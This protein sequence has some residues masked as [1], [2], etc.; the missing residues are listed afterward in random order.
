MLDVLVRV[1]IVLADLRGLQG[2]MPC[3]PHG[4]PDVGDDRSS[5]LVGMAGVLGVAPP[6]IISQHASSP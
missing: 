5:V 1:P 2:G 4:V 3:V 6:Y